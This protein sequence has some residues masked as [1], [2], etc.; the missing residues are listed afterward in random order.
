MPDSLLTNFQ[1]FR[2][3]ASGREAIR[4]W[5][6]PEE[7]AS[8][9]TPTRVDV[10]TIS[11]D[12]AQLVSRDTMQPGNGYDLT[13]QTPR[14]EITVSVVA[15]WS[16]PLAAYGWSVG[17][18]FNG[19]IAA[20]VMDELAE[21]QYL[22]RRRDDRLPVEVPCC[23]ATEGSIALSDGVIRDFS[24][25]GMCVEVPADMTVGNKLRVQLLTAVQPMFLRVRW[26]HCDGD[27]QFVGCQ[28]IMDADYTADIREAMQAE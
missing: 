26:S 17:C 24:R 10:D 16:V 1:S 3:T 18:V 25:G 12:A 23:V 11:C 15:R 14:A 6:M 7:S 20:D 28:T 4:A 9:A 22:E 2:L 8:H 5:I 27:E 13:L 19:N 21:E